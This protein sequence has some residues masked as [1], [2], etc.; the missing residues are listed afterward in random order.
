M[1]EAAANGLEGEL[2]EIVRQA[3]ERRCH[4][5]LDHR[6]VLFI[7]TGSGREVVVL[8]DAS[9]EMTDTNRRLVEVFCGRLAVAFDNV[10]LYQQ[11]QDANVRLEERVAKRTAELKS[12]NR[13]L[14]AQSSEL[15][16]ANRFKSEILGTIAHDLKNPL[17]VI[18][19][20]S[21]MLI[22]LLAMH[23]TPLEQVSAQIGHVRESA[24][25]LTGMVDT[26]ISDA[27]TDALDIAI[28]RDPV[29]LSALVRDVV[30]ANRPLADR[31]EQSVAIEGP[32]QLVACGD[33][34]RLFEAVDN[35]VSNAIKY[36]PR[37]GAN[38]PRARAETGIG[39]ACGSSIAVPAS[40][41]KTSGACS[42]DS[43]ASRPSRPA[44]RVRRGSG[45]PSPSASSTSMAGASRPRAPVRGRGPRSRSASPKEARSRDREP[46]HRRGRRRGRRTRHGGRLP[47][48]HG[49]TVTLCDGG[50][51]LR[52]SLAGGLKADLIVLDLNMPDED[53]L[54]IVR[55]LKRERAVP[56]IMLTATASPIDRVVGLEL[57]ADDYV[58]KP[59]E[60]REL[61]ARIRSVLRRSAVAPTAAP[62]RAENRVRFGTKWLDLDAHVLRDDEGTSQPL[63][64]VRVRAA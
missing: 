16:R 53:G 25:R 37:G 30:E 28:R 27:M 55:D 50:P 22:D 18:M 42:D 5:F 3:L 2:G 39:P 54:S 12:S 1:E 47:Q 11:L 51:S 48:M 7:Q 33:Q 57:G 15:R 45:C 38:P 56:V 41:R 19:G 52:K 64:G 29:D 31:K 6:Y 8:L 4:E 24:K 32:D 20:R 13:R 43:S 59:C 9:K 44:A 10:I 26:L 40:R 35:L 61:V 60:L 17:G 62:P 21:E 14:A 58:A 46:A 63:T 34:D 23:P 49:F 36:S